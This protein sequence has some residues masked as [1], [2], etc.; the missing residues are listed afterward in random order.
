MNKTDIADIRVTITVLKT[1]FADMDAKLKK[2]QEE[3]PTSELSYYAG[4]V[5]LAI[6]RAREAFIETLYR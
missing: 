6:S 4:H 2:L 5:R 1:I 3:D